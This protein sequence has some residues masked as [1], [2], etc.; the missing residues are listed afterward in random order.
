MVIQS[1]QARL[2]QIGRADRAGVRQTSAEHTVGQGD[3]FRSCRAGWRVNSAPGVKIGAD[4][5]ESD[6]AAPGHQSNERGRPTRHPNLGNRCQIQR[7]PSTLP[8][9]AD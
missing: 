2:S 6:A 8:H 4:V 7:A 5:S 3:A 9:R 1:S